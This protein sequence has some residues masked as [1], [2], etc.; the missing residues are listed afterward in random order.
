MVATDRQAAMSAEKQMPDDVLRL[1]AG[2]IRRL[3]GVTPWVRAALMILTNVRWGQLLIVLP[4]GRRLCFEGPEGEEC[5]ILIVQD[6][7]FAKRLL[8]GGGI[9]FAEAYL[10]G[11]WDQQRQNYDAKSHCRVDPP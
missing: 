11:W 8:T 4:D 9:G 6:L 5:G 2:E 7:R 3:P 10:D 1:S